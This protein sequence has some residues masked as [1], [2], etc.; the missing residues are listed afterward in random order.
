MILAQRTKMSGENL[1]ILKHQRSA[2][3]GEMSR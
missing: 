1:R 3:E 2:E